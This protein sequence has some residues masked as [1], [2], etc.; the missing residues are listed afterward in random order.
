[1]YCMN[2]RIFMNMYINKNNDKRDRPGQTAANIN[3]KQEQT[4]KTSITIV[5]RVSINKQTKINTTSVVSI[6]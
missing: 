2:I 1:M 5:V 4:Y 6:E 3:I